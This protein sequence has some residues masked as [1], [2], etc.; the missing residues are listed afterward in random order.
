MN[1]SLIRSVLGRVLMAAGGLALAALLLVTAMPLVHLAPRPVLSGSMEPTIP[2]GSLLVTK[3]VDVDSLDEG[4]VVTMHIGNDFLTHRIVDTTAPGDPNALVTRG[5]ANNAND[6]PVQ[7]DWVVGVPVVSVP[8]VGQVLVWSQ[9][10]T[11]MLGV[12]L[13]PLLLMLAGAGLRSGAGRPEAESAREELR[14]L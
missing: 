9:S 5:D 3:P 4:D 12:L 7:R 8:Y 14:V 1:L 11:G 2:T 10:G 13:T 6:A